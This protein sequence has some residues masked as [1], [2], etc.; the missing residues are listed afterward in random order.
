MAQVK[1][2][3]GVLSIAGEPIGGGGSGE[4]TSVNGKTGNVVL[5]YQDV[6]ALSDSTVIPD[7][8]SQLTNDAGY[9]T[10]SGLSRVATTG[11]Y[12]D[13]IN[14]PTIPTV[15]TDVSD[16]NNDAGYITAGIF[17]FDSTT[18]EL[19]ITTEN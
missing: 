17:S 18:N 8:V 1:K 19:T 10:S 4:V 11:D 9:I 3:V 5:N 12:N 15:P 13:L 2:L 16:F 6:H 7:K 14:K